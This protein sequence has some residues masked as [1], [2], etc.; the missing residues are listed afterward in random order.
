PT[1]TSC[2]SSTAAVTPGR[3]SIP[4]PVPAARRAVPHSRFS[5]RARFARSHTRDRPIGA[6]SPASPALE[7]EGGDARARCDRPLGDRPVG[8]LVARRYGSGTL[9]I[10]QRV[11]SGSAGH[12]VRRS[13]GDLGHPAHGPS[14][15]APEHLLAALLPVGQLV[16]VGAGHA[17]GRGQ[18]RRAGGL[19]RPVGDGPRRGPAGARPPLL[20]PGP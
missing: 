15:R 12:V 16:H 11:G 1:A 9:S 20:P 7:A 2:T 18:Q 17:T 19:A 3:Y 14:R 5:S 8:V 4:T 10:H 13:D 6:W